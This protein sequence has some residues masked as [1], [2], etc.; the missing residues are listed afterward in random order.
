MANL[1]DKEFKLFSDLVYDAIG[2]NLGSTKKELVRTRLGKR[3][4]ALNIPTFMGYYKYVTGDNKEELTNLFDA[5]S[6]NLTSFFREEKHFHFLSSK[7]LPDLAADKKMRGDKTIRVWSSACSSGEEPYSIAITMADYFRSERGWDI[8]ILATDI[9]TRVLDAAEKGVYRADRLKNVPPQALKTYF[10]KGRGDNEGSYT[11]NDHLRDMVYIRRINLLAQSWPFRRQ[12]D[13]IFCRNV[14]IYFDK[15]TQTKVISRFF[16]YLQKGGYLFLGHAES[17]A[18]VDT[19]F[20]YVRPT[21]Y[22]KK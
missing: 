11:V 17:L 22:L 9:S 13:F 21:V 3:L 1:S 16:Q 14:L 4:R 6:T 2:I 5:I 20:E 10:I 19:P 12:F 18:G 15:Y 7:L 8:K